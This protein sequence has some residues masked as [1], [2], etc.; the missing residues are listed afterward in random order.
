MREEHLVADDGPDPR[1]AG[2][3]EPPLG[4]RRVDRLRGARGLRAPARVVL[5]QRHEALLVVRAEDRPGRPDQIGGVA[6]LAALGRSEKH[7]SELQALAYLGC[8]L[9]LEKKKDER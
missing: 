4:A 2:L 5:G 3:E 9:L 6:G 1:R 7:T 8:R